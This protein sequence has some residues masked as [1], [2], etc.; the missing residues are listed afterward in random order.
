MSADRDNMLAALDTILPEIMNQLADE[1]A[2]RGDV[3]EQCGWLWM[4]ENKR[5]PTTSHTHGFYWVGFDKF[6]QCVCYLPYA[7]MKNLE[8]D[9]PSG[10]KIHSTLSAA[11]YAAARAAGTMLAEEAE[12][13]AREKE[14]RDCPLCGGKGLVTVGTPPNQWDERCPQHKGE[15]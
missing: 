15:R 5:F 3:V 2:D 1:A 12:R 14:R 4:V 9:R 10:S 13:E 11:L 7:A 6:S 8:C